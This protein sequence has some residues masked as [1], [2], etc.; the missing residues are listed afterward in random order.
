M[1]ANGY[2]LTKNLCLTYRFRSKPPIMT[3]RIE[4]LDEPEK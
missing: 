3:E 2:G 4:S 1:N